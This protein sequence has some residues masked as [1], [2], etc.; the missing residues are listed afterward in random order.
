M[1]ASYAREKFGVAVNE[2]ATGTGDIRDRIWHAYLS[3][4]TLSE[5]DFPDDLK[6]DWNFIYSSLTKE[7]PSYN[8]NGEVSV[9]KVQNTLR[10]LDTETCVELAQR[11]C[12]LNTKLHWDD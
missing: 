8:D 6:E 11:I 1:R 4:H 5:K 3:F 9:G 7:E 12:D 2:M 10:V